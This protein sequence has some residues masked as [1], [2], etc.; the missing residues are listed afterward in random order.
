M[1][2][3]ERLY[4]EEWIGKTLG[5]EEMPPAFV[6]AS[7]IAFTDPALVIS[8]EVPRKADLYKFGIIPFGTKDPKKVGGKYGNARGETIEKTYPFSESFLRRR[9][10]VPVSGFYDWVEDPESKNKIPYCGYV[11]EQP[12]FCF[13]GI[14][15]RWID[16]ATQQ[17][18]KSFSI[19]TRDPNELWKRVHNRMPVILEP[20]DYELW[21]D[22]AEKSAKDL[23]SVL[24]IFPAERMAFREFSTKVNNTKNKNEAELV[25]VGNPVTV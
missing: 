6:N 10:L 11:L 8:N 12:F 17:E 2:D 22:P 20:E 3:A 15:D 24:N 21:I 25:P 14:Y 16:P 7:N 5:I 13:A 9:C 1:G 19:V 23:K 4:I 18:T